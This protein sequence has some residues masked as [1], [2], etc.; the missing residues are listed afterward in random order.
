MA[1]PKCSDA[2]FIAAFSAGGAEA[3]RDTYGIEEH[4]V[5]K[6]RRRLE[7]AY[8]QPINAPTRQP[9]KQYPHRQVLEVRN[10]SV[11]VGSDFHIWPGYEST[12]MRA[13]R[14]FCE[15]DDL[16]AIILNGDVFDF[17]NISKHP[18]IGWESTP[19]PKDELEAVQGYLDSLVKAVRR[20]G[21]R[22]VHTLGNHDARFE[23]RLA[24]VASEYKGI[25]GI[26]LSD[27]IPLWEK[28]WSCFIN[29]QVVV[30]HRWKGGIG[31]TRANALNAGKT[32]VTGHLHS[33]K[34]TPLTDYNGT[35]WGVDTG[36]VA[37]PDHKAF[38]DYT[39][40]AALD[41][42]SGF[43]VLTFRDG[44]LLPPELVTKWRDGVVSFRGQLH[45]V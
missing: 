41:W 18:P 16:S 9:I 21:V 2:E 26:H 1:P 36:C 22:K 40:D 31:A 6:R 3:V 24:T 33:Q 34:V 8:G 15:M 20:R 14:K 5:Y 23:T 7:K 45:E 43:A 10:G 32:M 29:D 28:G 42:R 11:L 12:A 44:E 30:K 27:H 4:N 35:R 37:D 13:F 25:K 17:P 38:V 19:N 39:E